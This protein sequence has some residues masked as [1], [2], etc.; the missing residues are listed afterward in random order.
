MQ[1]VNA[2]SNIPTLPRKRR[3]ITLTRGT[4]KIKQ[5]CSLKYRYGGRV[6]VRA[7]HTVTSLSECLT[8][9]HVT[10]QWASDLMTTPATE[11]SI[12]STVTTISRGKEMVD[13]AR[14][15]PYPQDPPS[16]LL[17]PEYWLSSDEMELAVRLFCHQRPGVKCQSTLLIQRKEGFAP[18]MANSKFAQV[19]QHYILTRIAELYCEVKIFLQIIHTDGHWL[20]VTNV[21][22]TVYTRILDSLGVNLDHQVL[23]GI[24][25]V[26]VLSVL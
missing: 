9:P 2:E 6:G 11:K 5:R 13:L 21:G 17:R 4:L 12:T 10:T 26:Y 24:A 8:H 7:A 25:S 19:W 1:A 15:A 22:S 20:A 3:R 18:I 14:K 16:S 23:R